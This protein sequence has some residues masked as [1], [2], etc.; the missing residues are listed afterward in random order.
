M[1]STEEEDSGKSAL[2]FCEALGCSDIQRKG[3]IIGRNVNMKMFNT[4]PLFGFHTQKCLYPL[5]DVH[6]LWQVRR[7]LVGGR[8]LEM[9]KGSPLCKFANGCWLDV[10]QR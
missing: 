5:L 6:C 9:N 1:G 4:F 10:S 3:V 7:S 8:I 2:P